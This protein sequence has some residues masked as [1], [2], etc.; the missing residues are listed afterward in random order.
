MKAT[1]LIVFIL[2]SFFS[3]TQQQY[4]IV[5]NY[6][7]KKKGVKSNDLDSLLI[8]LIYEQ[9]YYFEETFICVDTII[10]EKKQS[11]FLKNVKIINTK[12]D[13]LT[14]FKKVKEIEDQ[15]LIVENGGLYNL[16]DALLHKYIQKNCSSISFLETN[17]SP[18]LIEYHA[19]D[20]AGILNSNNSVILHFNTDKK[21]QI[22]GYYY[23]VGDNNKS[24]YNET[25]KLLEE[26][27]KSINNLVFGFNHTKY[28]ICSLSNGNETIIGEGRVIFSNY[29]AKFNDFSNSYNRFIYKNKSGYF[30]VD[31][32]GKTLNNIPFEFI[33][34]SSFEYKDAISLV[35]QNGKYF[36]IN[37]NVEPIS[38]ERYHQVYILDA[39]V[40]G[41]TVKKNKTD[42]GYFAYNIYG[43]PFINKM[44]DDIYT[45]GKYETIIVL[46]HQNKFSLIF[47]DKNTPVFN[48]TTEPVMIDDRDHYFLKAKNKNNEYVLFNETNY[49]N[50]GDYAGLGLT[51]IK[52]AT[53]NLFLDS[54]II[55]LY[56]G[57]KFSL[58]FE[59]S[60]SSEKKNLK[61]EYDNYYINNNLLD[62]LEIMMVSK[63]GKYGLIDIYSGKE[64]SK[65]NYDNF[66]YD[67]E[68]L[69][70][71]NSIKVYIGKK[72]GVLYQDRNGF[73][74]ELLPPEYDDIEAYD[75]FICVE[76][77]N[78]YAIFYAD[79][80]TDFIFTEKPT[81]DFFYYDRFESSVKG[82]INE[83]KCDCYYHSSENMI[84]C[85]EKIIKPK[86]SDDYY[87]YLENEKFGIIG[88]NFDTVVSAKF[89]K[90]DLHPNEDYL[91]TSI[92]NKKGIRTHYGQIV[93]DEKFDEL[94]PDSQYYT[95]FTIV[96]LNDKWGLYNN[97]Q[98]AL[99]LKYEE[100]I[101]SDDIIY[102]KLNGKWGLYNYDLKLILEPKYKNLK[103]LKDA[104][105]KR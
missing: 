68:L 43:K 91:L 33:E 51:D 66:K 104:Y 19:K 52:I 16:Y 75:E 11:S 101:L 102:V 1:Y 53:D 94:I 8:P 34:E 78:K 39:F 54:P 80:L 76:K 92:N 105:L 57:N 67:F 37:D 69:D 45:I 100:I 73:Y 72:Q 71:Y 7:T 46:K 42:T 48:Y 85:Y 15:F 79:K 83:K 5:N 3:F 58:R 32:T 41:Y 27:I 70:Y 23:L 59:Q 62:E 95:E 87:F 49:L 82:E 74:I 56:K 25:G 98:L 22:N 88:T 90:I 47:D 30:V 12:G 50:G 9:I 84:T 93:I 14:T 86:W 24:I 31:S 38:D 103:T 81:N 20:K 99:E 17:Q 26:N 18:F 96:K 10:Y 29:N 44:L 35:K 97:S 13:V 36:F 6:E 63:N 55:L 2:T 89:D 4:V 61:F 21:I 65:F 28:K 40:K 60:D 64:L 77:N